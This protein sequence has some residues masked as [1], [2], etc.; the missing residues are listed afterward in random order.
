MLDKYY[1]PELVEQDIYTDWEEKGDFNGKVDPNKESFTIV[2]PPPNVTGNLHMGHAL[3]NTLQDILIRYYRMQGKDVLWQPG[4]DHAGIATEMVVERELKKEGTKKNS[5]SREEF[6]KQV[7]KWKETSGNQIINQ[8]KRLGCSCDWK[9]ERFTLDEGLSKAV[10]YVFVKLFED[11]L[12][13]KDKRLSNWDPKLKTTISD[14]EVIQ[15]ESKGSLWYID[16]SI[17]DSEEIITVA[18]TRPETML[19]DT[20]VA[21]HPDDE[22][23]KHLVGKKAILPIVEK[24]IKIIADDYAKPDQGSGVV[25]VTPAHDFNDFEVGKRHNLEV[26]NIFN[27]DATLND[28]VPDSYKHLDRFKA[29]EKIIADLEKTGKLNKVEEILHTVPFGDRSNEIIEPWLTDQWF[30]N[31]KELSKAAI[32]KVRDKETTFIPSNWEKTYFEWMENIQ[33]W[34]VSRQLWWGHQIPAWYGPDGKI[35]VAENLDEA[36]NNAKKHYGRTVDLKQEDDV[37]DTWFSSALWPFSTLGWPEKTR[38]LSNYYPTSTLVTGFDIIFFW[39]ARM[40]MMGLYFTGEVPFKEVYVHALVRDEKGQKMSKSKGNVID[41]LVLMNKYGSDSL[42]MTLCSMAAQGRDIKLSEQRVE[43]YRNFITKIWNAVKFCEI[44]KCEYKEVDINELK[45]DFNLWV[46]NELDK[47][48]KITQSSIE[49]YKFNEAANELYRFTWNVFCDWYLEFSKNIY[50]NN[51]DEE[52]K[53][54]RN[55]TS[56]ILKNILIMLHPIM[57]FFTEYL[58]KEASS[59]LGKSQNKVIHTG[60]SSSFVNKKV[61]CEQID[62]LINV[63]S[64]IR[65]TRSELNVPAK[66]NVDIYFDPNKKLENL[67]NLYSSSLKSMARASPVSIKNPDENEGM[68]QVILNDGLIYLSLKD[69]ID[70]KAES[71][72][73]SKNLDKIETEIVKINKK[74]GDKSFISNAPEEVVQEQKERLNDYAISKNKIEKAIDSIS[75]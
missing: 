29:R 70:F 66:A 41:P 74:L 31:A 46:M 56:Y 27:D 11:G 64:L 69:I 26:I 38:E 22:R 17:E 60:W 55:V 7:W 54:T 6:I 23:Y 42:R 2:I 39:V 75:S 32:Q 61:D 21:V 16:Y 19:G 72:R 49:E 3:N 30:V 12:I 68:V 67:F 50:D 58:W 65:S 53:E 10:K 51:N 1:K 24:K 35:F 25:K 47:C 37:L 48:K 9:R 62:E 59:V 34:C 15:K 40:M 4:T 71:K 14:L 20:A 63:I 5:L 36:S 28:N 18:T 43:G 73:L 52:I 33:P 8:L 45:N 57:P 44:N 13:Y